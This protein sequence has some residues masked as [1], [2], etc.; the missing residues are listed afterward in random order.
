[1]NYETSLQEI[2]HTAE[3]L[4]MI[5][6]MYNENYN[7]IYFKV[8]QAIKNQEV[9]EDLV[10]EIFC[11]ASQK[12]R[13]YN[14]EKGEINTWLYNIANNHI[15]DYIRSDAN[16][17]NKNTVKVNGFVNEDGKESFDFIAPVSTNADKDILAGET[18][19]Q[20]VAAF[21]NLKPKYRRIAS[22]YFIS[23]YKYSKIATIL[24]VPEGTVK[25][26][27]NRARTMLQESLKVGQTA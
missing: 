24:N 10:A 27:I 4:K 26:M 18:Q 14:S 7:G 6:K 23:G 1:M 13:L 19:K 11:K 8:L 5:T 20:I 21:H 3:E 25:G 9:V 17:N 16:K 2:D 22:L 15:I 12:I